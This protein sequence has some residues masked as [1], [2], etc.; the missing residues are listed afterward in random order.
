MEQRCAAVLVGQFSK[1]LGGVLSTTDCSANSTA[2]CSMYGPSPPKRWPH[3]DTRHTRWVP[4][5]CLSSRPPTGSRWFRRHRRV[6]PHTAVLK[7]LE[8]T[9]N[10]SHSGWCECGSHSENTTRAVVLP[11][12]VVQGAWREP[13]TR[14]RTAYLPSHCQEPTN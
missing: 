8:A 6:N 11:V 3:L 10:Y 9:P 5:A 7:Q 12:W 4:F 14:H 2:T 13:P 1:F